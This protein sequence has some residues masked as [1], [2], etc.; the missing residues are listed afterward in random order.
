MVGLGALNQLPLVKSKAGAE[1]LGLLAT[2]SIS[3]GNDKR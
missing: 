2:K 3:A 1:F